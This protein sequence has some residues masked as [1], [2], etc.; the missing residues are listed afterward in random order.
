MTGGGARGTGRAGP[1]GSPTVVGER[2]GGVGSLTPYLDSP[3][4]RQRRP[5]TELSGVRSAAAECGSA[6]QRR[7]ARARGNGGVEA[8]DGWHGVW[9]REGE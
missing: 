7:R 1:A 4:K 3:E 2:E 8:G 5:A 9:R 6:E